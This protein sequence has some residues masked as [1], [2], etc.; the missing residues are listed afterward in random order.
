MRYFLF[1]FLVAGL[2][3]S[4]CRPSV[5]SRPA[6]SPPPVSAEVRTAREAGWPVAIADLSGFRG[7]SNDISL[8]F[9]LVNVSDR[10]IQR[11]YLTAYVRNSGGDPLL[12]E[13]TRSIYRELDYAVPLRPGEVRWGETAEIPMAFRHGQAATIHIR[14][15]RV[16][17]GDGRETP[18]IRVEGQSLFKGQIMNAGG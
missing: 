14:D 7:A 9:T 10:P 17:F 5:V 1:T 3:V 15:L 8:R 13:R 6:P 18:A 2:L 4:G 11:V 16:V 12:D